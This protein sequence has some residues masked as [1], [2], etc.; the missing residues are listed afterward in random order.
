MFGP[1]LMGEIQIDETGGSGDNIELLDVGPSE[2]GP[3]AYV[4]NGKHFF[5]RKTQKSKNSIFSKP[6]FLLLLRFSSFFLPF[7]LKN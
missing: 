2:S 7:S 4:N 6:L 5:F 1:P 3:G